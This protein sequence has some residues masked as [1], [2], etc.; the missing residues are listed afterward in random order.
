M[1][2]VADQL[3][4]LPYNSEQLNKIR[5]YLAKQAQELNVEMPSIDTE[6]SV[7]FTE[8]CTCQ[9]CTSLPPELSYNTLLNP[10][11]L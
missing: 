10:I 1:K 5:D 7:F 2:N 4:D 8:E 3:K 6:V 11:Q 9:E